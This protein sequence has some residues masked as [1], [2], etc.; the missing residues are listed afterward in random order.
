MK[1]ALVMLLAGTSSQVLA[2]RPFDSTD[3]DVA[4]DGEFE[5]ELE[6]VGWL[7]EGSAKFVVA[8]AVVANI[9]LA[10]ER[11]L[12]LQ[13]QRQVLQDPQPGEPRISLVDTGLFVKQM[14]RNGVLQDETGPSVAT[15]FG[16]LL[17]EV[18]GQSGTGFSWAGIVS[19]RWDAMTVHLNAEAAITRTHEPGLF[20][21]AIFEGPYRWTV[22]PVAEVFTDKE[23]GSPRTNSALVGA[24]WRVSKDLTFD[25]GVREARTGGEGIH[26]IR[27]GLTWS[28]PWKT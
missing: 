21:G 11:E 6:P 18:H 20:L 14:L 3:A 13:G 15:E 24:I 7:R 28:F 12:V 16:L 23:S 25:F 8:P 9:G 19:Q 26:E 22:R 4:A 5:L 17:P 2:Y 1:V 27:L 10:G